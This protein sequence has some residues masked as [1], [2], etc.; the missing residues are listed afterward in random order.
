[1]GK[2]TNVE[3][4]TF[5]ETTADGGMPA[6][7]E[8]EGE[9]IVHAGDTIIPFHAIEKAVVTEENYGTDFPDPYMC[10]GGEKKY[11]SWADG[12]DEEI[13]AMLEAHYA[14]EINIYDYWSVGDTRKIS[15]SAMSASNGLSDTHVAQ[16]IEMVLANAG[17]KTLADG[18]AECAFIVMQKDCLL[19]KGGVITSG[20]VRMGWADC[21]RRA[22]CNGT[23]LNAFPDTIKS[24][25]KAYKNKTADGNV[26][27]IVE[28][29]DTFAL[30]AE[31]EVFGEVQ[32][33][34]AYEGLE[35]TQFSAL[36]YASNRLKKLG[37]NG[38]ATG[39]W[40]RSPATGFTNQYCICGQ[41][42]EKAKDVGSVAYGIAPFGVI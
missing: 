16:D 25:F 1:M 11:A 26:S 42:G 29:T 7:Y 19:E 38:N 10:K 20:D 17:G 3:I 35:L 21:A 36:S 24:I 32:F 13:V 23:Y 6:L 33:S 37:E 34:W 39:Y 22:W 15:L 27:S 18:G 9:R 5:G 28:T 8:V 31:K 2:V 41:I 12:T 14:G 40:L 4:T 30:I